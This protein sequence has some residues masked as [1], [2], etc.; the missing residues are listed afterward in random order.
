MP[1]LAWQMTRSRCASISVDSY[2]TWLTNTQPALSPSAETDSSESNHRSAFLRDV[3]RHRE[4]AGRPLL[5]RQRIRQQA[6]D[7]RRLRRH[8]HRGRLLRV[9]GRSGDDGVAGREASRPSIIGYAAD[10]KYYDLSVVL[11][12]FI[13]ITVTMKPRN[14]VQ[15][16]PTITIT[17]I[18]GRNSSRT[19]PATAMQ[20]PTI[21]TL[22]ALP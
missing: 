22:C 1:T 11:L 13:L 20:N 18:L 17:P 16:P 10:G 8:V 21:A 15:R 4:A 12:R 2:G 6:D 14:I 3:D 5:Q 7:R 9:V 19:M